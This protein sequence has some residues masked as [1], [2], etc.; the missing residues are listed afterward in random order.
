MNIRPL[1]LY[2][3][4]AILSAFPAQALFGQPAAA[5]PPATETEPAPE[6][7]RY[8]MLIRNTNHLKAAVET[9]TMLRQRNSTSVEQFEV[10]ICGKAVA[11][12]QQHRELI[13]RARAHDIRVSACG[14]SLHKFSVSPSALPAGVG[15][16]PNGLIRMFELQEQGYR[17]ISL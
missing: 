6:G 16:V 3:S 12:L 4:I 9:V 8:A 10:V 2:L 11:R 5:P 7:K 1:I 15:V 17:T 13:C 14:M